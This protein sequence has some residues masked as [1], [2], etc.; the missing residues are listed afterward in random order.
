MVE[1]RE[2]ASDP[3]EASTIT[4]AEPIISSLQDEHFTCLNHTLMLRLGTVGQA[5]YLRVIFHFANL[6]TGVNGSPLEFVK[7]YDD[8]CAEWL[9]GLK[10]LR[11]ESDI[12]RKLGPHLD[13]VVQEGVLSRFT[14]TNAKD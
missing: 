10:V 3:I 4:V 1:R 6:C 14:L 7:R 2:F 9:G 13:Q 5:L 12:R 11:Y 8:V